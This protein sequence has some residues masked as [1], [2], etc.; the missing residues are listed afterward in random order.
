MPKAASKSRS[1]LLCIIVTSVD[2]V[3][4]P[5]LELER[6]VQKNSCGMN[7]NCSRGEKSRKKQPT[8]TRATDC[9]RATVALEIHSARDA[10]NNEGLQ[11]LVQSFNINISSN[12]TEDGPDTSNDS[13]DFHTV[14]QDTRTQWVQYNSWF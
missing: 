2:V 5:A 7:M 8:S 11:V 13:C 3:A 10:N 12:R 6:A 1:V 14:R 9:E 4:W